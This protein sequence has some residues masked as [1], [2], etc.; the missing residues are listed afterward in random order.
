MRKFTIFLA[1]MVFIGL[2]VAHAQRTITG[3]VTSSDDGAG[4][5]GATVL[6]KGTAIGSITD[7]DGKY[8]LTVPKDKDVLLVSYVGMRPQEIQLGTSNVVDVVLEPATITLDDVVVTAL[9]VS[10]EKKALGYAVQDVKGEDLTKAREPNLINSLSGK[11]AGVQVTNASGA[12][13]ASS[14]IVLRGVNSLTGNNQPLFVV[15]G[16][17]INNSDFGSTTNEGVNRGSGAMDINPNDVENISVLKGPNAAALYGSRAA[18]GVILITTKSGSMKAGKTKNLGIEVSNTTMFESPFRLPNFQNGYGQGSGGA[19]KFVDGAGGGINDGTDESWG[20]KL[21]AGLLITQFDSPLDADGNRI[22]TPWVSHK[23]NI[24]NFFETGINT[25]TNVAISGSGEYASA[26]LSYTQTNQKGMVPNT[27]YTTKTVSLGL[28]GNPSK[29]L[30]ISGSGNYIKA[31]SKNQPGYGYDAQNVMQQ[32]F[33]FGRQVDISKLKTYTNP[34]GSKYNWNYNFHNNPYFTL[35]ENLNALTRDRV[36]GNAKVLFKIYKDFSAFVRTG[37]DYYTNLNQNRIAFED[38]DNAYGYYGEVKNTF[39]E[40]NTDFLLMYNHKFTQA[41]LELQ[42]NAGGNTM[43]QYRY[44][45]SATAGELAVPGVYNV[46]NSR[47]AVTATNRTEHKRL[48]SLY[49][50]G[51]LGWR[52]AVYLDFTGRNDWSSTLPKDQWS[53][54]YPS[55][56]LSGIITELIPAKTD[57]LPYAKVRIS[58]A[59]VGSDT[60]PYSLYPTLS[61]GD[62][63]STTYSGLTQFVPNTLPNS[64]LKP[65]FTNSLEIGAELKFLNNRIS[66][67]VTYYN[68]KTTDQILNAP[69]SSATGY[70]NKYINAGEIDNKGFE[71]TLG[72]TAIKGDGQKKINWD[73]QLNYAKNQNKVVELAPGVENFVLGTY[74]DLKVIAQPGRPYGDLYGYDYKR[75]PN[76]NVIHKNGVPLKGDL[77]VLGNYQPDWVGGVS[78]KFSWYGFTLSGLVDFHMGGELYSMTTTWGRYSG[79]LDETLIGREGGIVG[80]GVKE[81]IVDGKVTYVPND[82]VVTSEEYNHAAFNNNLAGGSVFDASYI[83]LRELSIGYTFKQILKGTFKD[84]TISIVGRNLALLYSK[85]P[86]VDPETSFSNTNVQGLE[87]GQLPSARSLGFNISFKL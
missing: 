61:F 82:V 22:A 56:S 76:G 73:I 27:D 42:L 47:I 63:F 19:F 58:W 33:W 74:W 28:T 34:D 30:N 59:K 10:R 6:V 41:K 2:Q 21:D 26:R 84:V 65:Q 77:K 72:A 57:I 38:I 86:H 79:V 16:V 66:L 43:D 7:V 60:D 20:P 69:V 37:I 25:S 31:T 55:V 70:Q 24:K 3:K 18:N 11:I 68:Q 46:S 71:V 80:E 35:N 50:S 48:N 62:P 12:V 39:K 44:N 67:D 49:F 8:S 45:M 40:M 36:Y 23:D 32:F 9:G 54:F 51:Q 14:R 75:D 1:L 83:K 85:V 15:D 78:T 53:Y 17:P 87:F 52:S 5:P 64:T 13:G 4:I 81:V 29:W